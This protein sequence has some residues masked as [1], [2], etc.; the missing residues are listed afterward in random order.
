[1]MF[2]TERRVRVAGSYRFRGTA[3]AKDYRGYTHKRP[4]KKK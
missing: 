4:A 2:A 1:V 3:T